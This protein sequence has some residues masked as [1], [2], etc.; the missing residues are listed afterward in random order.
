MNDLNELDF[1]WGHAAYP[2]FQEVFKGKKGVLIM[3]FQAA[4]PCVEK[5]GLIFSGV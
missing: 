4:E 5:K 2:V 3:S 1:N